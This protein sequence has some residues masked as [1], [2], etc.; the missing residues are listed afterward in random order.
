MANYSGHDAGWK[1]LGRGMT[2]S[3]IGAKTLLALHAHSI[4][5]CVSHD[6]ADGGFAR[7]V[8]TVRSVCRK[9]AWPHHQCE[10]QSRQQVFHSI[11]F[12]CGPTLPSGTRNR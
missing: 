9:S 8:F 1:F 4:G 10:E 12:H 6:W 3:A 7:G 5:I 2:A 11:R